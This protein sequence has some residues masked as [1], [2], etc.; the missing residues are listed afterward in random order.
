MLVTP[1]TDALGGDTLAGPGYSMGGASPPI[2]DLVVPCDEASSDNRIHFE[3]MLANMKNGDSRDT[4]FVRRA[5]ERDSETGEV[6]CDESND[7]RLFISYNP[8]KIRESYPLKPGDFSKGVNV[9]GV[10]MASLGYVIPEDY[11]IA[12]FQEIEDQV[13][14]DIRRSI[15]ILV[16]LIAATAAITTLFLAK[17][18]CVEIAAYIIRFLERR[19]HL[20]TVV[21]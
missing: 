3:T 18:R 10:L 7:E 17:V 5:F 8:V 19:S 13:D 6:T 4:S 16:G 2:Q 21:M 1:E 11:L 20:S 12:P 14:E 15:A 9:S